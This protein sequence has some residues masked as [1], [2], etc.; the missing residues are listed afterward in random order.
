MK[1]HHVALFVSDMDAALRLWRDVLG[2]N[3]RV[4]MTIPDGQASGP[5]VYFSGDLLDQ[6]LGA[7]GSKSRMVIVWSAEGAV[8]ELQECAT[9]KL[10]KRPS[11]RVGYR[12]TGILELALQ[13]KNIDGWFEKVRGAGYKTQTD[14]VW[15]CANILRSFLFYD[16]DGNLIQMCEPI[17]T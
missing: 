3:V 7:R 15:S 16:Q 17:E 11:E 12:E 4:D 1:I 13:V 10:Q 9:P 14:G 5:N 2:F 6:I 8:V